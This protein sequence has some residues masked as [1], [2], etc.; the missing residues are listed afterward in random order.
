[1]VRSLTTGSAPAPITPSAISAAIRVSD[2]AFSLCSNRWSHLRGGDIPFWMRQG[3][4]NG[5]EVRTERE[6]DGRHT[7]ASCRLT[8]H[9]SFTLRINSMSAA[10]GAGVSAALSVAADHF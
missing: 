7:A 3:L 10:I 8:R 5:R 9:Y 6:D 1:M 4:Y 2:T